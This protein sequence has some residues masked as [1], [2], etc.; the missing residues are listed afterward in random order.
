M[1][2]VAKATYNL[3]FSKSCQRC[4][5]LRSGQTL[6]ICAS[7]RLGQ[8]NSKITI[9][10]PSQ[11]WH[12]CTWASH[13]RW[14]GGFTAVTCEPPSLRCTARV[15]FAWRCAFIHSSARSA[16][17]H[18]HS[19]YCSPGLVMR[20]HCAEFWRVRAALLMW[21]PGNLLFH[22]PWDKIGWFILCGTQARAG[23]QAR[24]ERW[25]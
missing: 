24:W 15:P 4:A 23:R 8:E 17:V 9:R 2:S 25:G 22:W 7:Q 3:D 11:T 5:T 14:A 21:L 6:F 10:V 1:G 20:S 18:F 13:R 12:C 16:A 19:V